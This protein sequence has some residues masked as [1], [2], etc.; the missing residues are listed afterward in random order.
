METSKRFSCHY[1]ISGGKP[2][3]IGPPK[4]MARGVAEAKQLKHP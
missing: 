3:E 1:G 4:Q 2:D